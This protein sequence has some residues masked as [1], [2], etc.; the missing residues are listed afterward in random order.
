[1]ASTF[2]SGDIPRPD[3][4]GVDVTSMM[5]SFD[6]SKLLVGSNVNAGFVRVYKY[7]ESSNTWS[8]ETTINGNSNDNMGNSVSFSWD[9]DIIAAGAPGNN[10]VYLYKDTSSSSNWSSYDYDTI[11]GTSSS[12]F[13]WSV[14]LSCD[15]GNHVA[16]GA[17]G[18]NKVY[19]YQK[20]GTAFNTWSSVYTRT[21]S[22]SDFY[23]T[24][25]ESSGLQYLVDSNGNEYAGTS[26]LIYL[27]VPHSVASVRF[28]HSVHLSGFGEYLAVGAPGSHVGTLNTS[29]VTYVGGGSPQ[30]FK[31]YRDVSP[32]DARNNTSTSRAHR[33]LG[34]VMCFKT[35][36][37]DLSWDTS[38]H[39]SS[40][41]SQHG[42][43]IEGYTEDDTDHMPANYEP[44]HA[45]GFPAA[46]TCVQ[47]S[48]DGSR[49]AVGSPYYSL[50][51]KQ[52]GYDVGRIDGYNITEGNT[53]AKAPG[54]VLGS[55]SHHMGKQFCLDYKGNRMGVSTRKGSGGTGSAFAFDFSGLGWYEVIP[56]IDWLG[57]P[58][59]ECCSMV[60]GQLLAS[61]WKDDPSVNPS[62]RIRFFHFT[63]TK[64]FTGNEI[65]SGYM[66]ADTVKIGSNNSSTVTDPS[67]TNALRKMITFGG[68]YFDNTYD[69]T[70][71][72]NRAYYYNPANADIHQQGWSELLFR[73]KTNSTAYD[74]I[75]FKSNEFRIDNYMPGDG[76]YDHNP[77]LT[78]D[79]VGNFKLNAEMTFSH[80]R[81]QAN[82]QALLDIEGDSL[83]R[84]RACIG[85]T[86]GN[87]TLGKEKFPFNILY[88]TRSA[89][90]KDG[91]NSV[92]LVSNVCVW[93]R[94][95]GGGATRWN[96]KGPITGTINY[97]ETEGAISLNTT[98][99]YSLNTGQDGTIYHDGN[100]TRGG[101]KLSFWLKLQ[102]DHNTYSTKTL[103]G[104]GDLSN[105]GVTGCRVQITSDR[106][107][108]N[109]GQYQIHTSSAYTFTKDKWYHIYV[110]SDPVQR[111]GTSYSTIR[112]NN[113]A[114]SLSSSGSVANKNSDY[115]KKFYVGS[116]IGSDSAT[117]IYIGNIAFYPNKNASY[118]GSPDTASY[119]DLYNWGPPQQKLAVG[120]D[121]YVKSR[122][123]INNFT[124]HYPLDI[125]GDINISSGSSFRING[126]AQ[127]FGGGGS[128][129]WTASGSDVYRSSGNVGI[130]TTSPSRYL[131]VAGTLNATN[132]GLLVR[133]G[134]DNTASA[135]APQI[136]FGWNGN[137]QYKH[138]IRT[139]HNSSA[140][141]NSID[142][143]VCDSTQNNSLTSGVTHNLTLES[144]KVGMN[145]V[146]EPEAPLHINASSTGT[147]PSSNGIYV[148]QSDNNKNAVMGVRV[149]GNG[150][151]NPYFSWDIEG[152]AGWSAG[153]DNSNGDVWDLCEN[154]DLNSSSGNVV[155]QAVRGSGRTKFRVYEHAGNIT[156]DSNWP[157]WGGGFATWDILCMSMSYSGL[158]QRSDRNLKDNIVDIPVGLS[159]IL[160][161]RPVR[162]T[163]K[164][165]PDGGP[166]YGLIAQEAE[167]IIPELVRNDGDNNT[168][169]IKQEIVPIL[170]KATQELNTKVTTLETDNASLKTQVA[171]LETQVADLISRVTA[172][173]NA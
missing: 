153:I 14:S 69:A 76:D 118:Y 44:S 71:I 58:A 108:M 90:V 147:G 97:H 145:G 21:W 3:I 87:N 64:M 144:G 157:S 166:H 124:P 51:G 83:T 165:V 70:E 16:V 27:R 13:G 81:G 134:D 20:S 75:R 99:S 77:R 45:F 66:T 89:L 29:D 102:N 113:A 19:V 67:T 110:V 138:F 63:L 52:S 163:W 78:M 126:V 33:Q 121:A 22:T 37:S 103:I 73:K 35:S 120:G 116:N 142:F 117:N 158:S 24:I 7:T 15:I 172:L 106:I 156:G 130:G 85:W 94:G 167:S 60:N 119:T 101:F 91:N 32:Y 39:G 155:A 150:S 114:Q 95:V 72:E 4:T 111:A 54:S 96:T 74:M 57:H 53:W 43:T 133:N 31:C 129:A 100:S 18:E 38:T 48:L 125:D 146:T 82:V 84:R 162:Y 49:L 154:W 56:G 115:S 105:S 1:M 10:K 141:N 17:P 86:G 128:G 62:G 143:Y 137:D 149:N 34:H 127:S 122:L 171:T 92:G 42:D 160:Q 88:D 5:L 131:D 159:Q 23:N 68:T 132:G 123:G 164:D 11:S 136:T 47:I 151:G 9:G 55:A 169:R 79:V 107:Q 168:Y 173:E 50:A 6:N 98:S 2:N 139:R 65:V 93:N 30:Y 59:L 40:I 170:I 61:G 140:D 104:M 8:T 12:L 80:E 148:R 109:F 41:I 28:G 25:Y 135:N 46:G 26:T 112:I 36:R 161:L 152:V